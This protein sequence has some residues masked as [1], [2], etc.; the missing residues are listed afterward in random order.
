MIN[1]ETV[2]FICYQI[3]TD[4]SDWC[5]REGW[6]FIKEIFINRTLRGKNYGVKLVYHAETKLYAK[7]VDHIYLT[8]DEAGEFW[9]LCG[10]RN[11]GI[12]SSINHDPIYE[13]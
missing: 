11:T 4:K 12:V 6:G 1:G 8:S 9:N 7:G 3:D 2:G 10:Y 13:K 5:E